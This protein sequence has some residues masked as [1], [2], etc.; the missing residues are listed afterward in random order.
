MWYAP[1]RSTGHRIPRAG[2]PGSGLGLGRSRDDLV[3]CCRVRRSGRYGSFP[4]L[5]DGGRDRLR[6]GTVLGDYV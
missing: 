2:I 1:G 4:H 5:C 6:T 3:V